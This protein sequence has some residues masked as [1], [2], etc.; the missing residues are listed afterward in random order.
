[1]SA[2]AGVDYNSVTR[3]S[4][5]RPG[6][7]AMSSAMVAD[8]SILHVSGDDSSS[9]ILFE[10]IDGQRVEM[11]RMSVYAGILSAR[12]VEQ[13]VIHNHQQT[14]R[15]GRIFPEF[16]FRLPLLEATTRN[17]RPE[18]AFVSFE[19]APIN[20]LP[21]TRDD[22]WSV[23]PDLAVEVISP[24]DLAEDQLEKI[25]E[26]FVAGVRLVWV[27]YPTLGYLH[28]YSSPK[29]VQILDRVDTLDGGPVLP[30]FSM[31]LDLL[32]DATPP[33]SPAS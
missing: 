13:L 7:Q 31:P 2:R 14:P 11:P 12:L 8:P 28:V 18:I 4:R 29:T 25:L 16:L 19:R 23:V 27:V 6:E 20:Q 3:I 33:I 24:S 22:A 5:G 10:I 26:Y 21:S 30:G 32:F 15:P 9:E 1:M 17:R